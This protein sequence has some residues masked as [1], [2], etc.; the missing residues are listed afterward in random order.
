MKFKIG[1]IVDYGIHKNLEII[2]KNEESYI[3]REEDGSK[4]KIIKSFVEDKKDGAILRK[5][6]RA[7]TKATVWMADGFGEWF[8]EKEFEEEIASVTLSNDSYVV[9]LEKEDYF[10][11]L[12][13]LYDARCYKI[14]LEPVER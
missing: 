9:T 1:D 3:L 14:T 13:Y 5:R 6:P 8:L 12:V 11:K 7:R 2:E 4:R 10:G